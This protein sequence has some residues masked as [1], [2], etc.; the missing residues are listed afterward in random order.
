MTLNDN[1]TQI[2]TPADFVSDFYSYS[3]QVQKK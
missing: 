2:F 1:N 3:V